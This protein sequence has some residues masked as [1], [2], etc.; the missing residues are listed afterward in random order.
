MNNAAV[1]NMMEA[2]GCASNHRLLRSWNHTKQGEDFTHIIG[3]K[4]GMLDR[5]IG[6]FLRREYPENNRQNVLFIPEKHRMAMRAAERETARQVF[7]WLRDMHRMG[8]V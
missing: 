8:N 7:E 5:I 4:I 3:S 6:L 2:A 1:M